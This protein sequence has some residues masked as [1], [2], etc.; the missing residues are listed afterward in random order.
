MNT[1]D[2]VIIF[3]L[4]SLTLLVFVLFIVL[5]LFEY[6]KRQVRHITEKMELRQRYNDEVLKT[7]IEVQEQTFKYIAEELHDN[8][9]QMLSLVKIKLYKAK[10]KTT[11]EQVI[12]G[13]DT[14]TELL[15]K[16]MDDL[17]TLSHTLSGGLITRIPFEK[18][19]EN[20]LNYIRDDETQ[21]TLRVSG[22]TREI[23]P[24][25]KL[26]AFRIVQESINN[27]IKHGKAR[28]IIVSLVYKTDVVTLAIED[29]GTGFDTGLMN[30]GNGLG[31]QNMR[32]RA[33]MLGRF[34]IV[35]GKQKGTT[36]TL[37]INTD[38]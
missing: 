10:S 37:N 38:E 30:A 33:N 23:A 8:I 24:D 5:I 1:T 27:A 9:A 20:E 36:I 35:S 26:M 18:S 11:D 3:I 14:G 22:E 31:L 16:T 19:L 4:G 6:R 34:S 21:A 28:N 13:L 17:R 15:S 32:L 2:N 7:Q 12:A 29:D 25:K